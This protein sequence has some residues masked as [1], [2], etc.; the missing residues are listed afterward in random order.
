MKRVGYPKIRFLNFLTSSKRFIS[1][2]MIYFKSMKCSRT[3][4]EVGLH[5]L[6]VHIFPIRKYVISGVPILFSANYKYKGERWL[7]KCNLLNI[8]NIV[9]L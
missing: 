2:L 8:P 6:T 1:G 9:P 3:I 5:K 7:K 4:T